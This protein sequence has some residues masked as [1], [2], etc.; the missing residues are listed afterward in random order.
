M[1]HYAQ[2]R[3]R[4]LSE[5]QESH[6]LRKQRPPALLRERGAAISQGFGGGA[7]E[8]Q[9]RLKRNAPAQGVSPQA[10]AAIELEPT[11]QRQLHAVHAVLAD[12]QG[13]AA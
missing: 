5:V 4:S 11:D 13:I 2:A 6:V 1:R 9:P 8:T 3:R 10:G 12:H 7:S